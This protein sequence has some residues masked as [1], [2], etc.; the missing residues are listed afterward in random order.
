[1]KTKNVTGEREEHFV[2]MKG[3]LHQEDRT[4]INIYVHN[5]G[6][7]KYMKQNLTEIEKCN[8]TTTIKKERDFSRYLYF[9][10]NNG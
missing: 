4:I 7:P 3:S 6:T 5:N 8:L 9:T 1:M 10:F 2:M